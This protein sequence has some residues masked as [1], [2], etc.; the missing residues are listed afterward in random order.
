MK[1]QKVLTLEDGKLI[2]IR[3]QSILN[4]DGFLKTNWFGIKRFELRPNDEY[5]ELLRDH[6]PLGAWKLSALDIPQLP[7][8]LNKEDGS[9]Q[10]NRSPAMAFMVHGSDGRRFRYLYFRAL[11]DGRFHIGTRTD[12]GIRYMS[13]CLSR[14]QRKENEILKL[15][16]LIR[17]RRV[18]RKERKTQRLLR[19]ELQRQQDRKAA[20]Q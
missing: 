15:K 19:G 9:F 3:V 1:K 2:K 20:Q 8:L 5:I 13:N 16:R 11:S 10:R 6:E 7:P 12:I 4:D 17:K 14:R 18:E